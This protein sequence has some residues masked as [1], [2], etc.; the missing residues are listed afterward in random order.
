MISKRIKS[1]KDGKSSAGDSLRYGEGLKVD[2]ETGEYLDKSH[3]T[4]FGGFGLVDD[5]V[6][7]DLGIESM[8]EMIDLASIEMQANCDL[9]TRVRKDKKIGHFVISFDQD[10]PTEAALRDTEDSMLAAMKLDNNHFA[11]FLHNDNGYWHLHM[12]ASRIEKN[13]PHRGNS[14]WNDQTIRDKVCREIEIRHGLK[15]DNGM[16][17]IDQLGLIVEI[18]LAD[19]RAAREAKRESDPSISDKAKTTEIYS[20]EKTFQSWVNEIRMGDRLKHAK[21]WKDLHAAAAAYNCE[22]RIKSGGFILCPVGDIGG[23]QLSKIGLKNLPAKFGAFQ[24]ALPGSRIEPESIYKPGPTLAKAATHYEKWSVAKAAFKPAKTDRI[25]ELR[26][27][28]KAI[29]KQV[30]AQQKADIAKIYA[31]TSGQGKTADVSIAKMQYVVVLAALKDQF[32]HERQALRKKLAGADP[33]KTFRDYLVIEAA[34]GD[35]IS[36]GF[37]REYGVSGSTDVLAKREADQLVIVAAISGREY[38]PAQR[39]NF[40][41]R[42]E[43]NGTVV[44]DFGQGRIVTDSAVSKQVQLNHAAAADPQAIATALSFAATKFGNILTL[45]GE[46]EFQRLAV[47]TAVRNG[48]NINFKDPTLQKYKQEFAASISYPTRVHHPTYQQIQKGLQNVINRSP[49]PPAHILARGAGSLGRPADNLIRLEELPTSSQAEDRGSLHELPVGSLDSKIKISGVLLPGAVPGHV[50]DQQTGE[51]SSVR[52]PGASEVGSAGSGR[53]TGAAGQDVSTGSG[54]GEQTQRDDAGRAVRRERP[55]RL[56]EPASPDRDRIGI[57]LKDATPSMLDQQAQQAAAPAAEIPAA[58]PYEIAA[59]TP[60]M[61]VHDWLK[62]WIEDTGKSIGTA[63]A[64]NEDTAYIIVHIAPDGIVLDK[65]RTGAV[66]STPAD[67][68]LQVGDKV[69]VSNKAELRLPRIL[70]RDK[71]EPK[72]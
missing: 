25:N 17:E 43:R 72:R 19:R 51:H 10:K 39:M 40:S 28:H 2:R 32:A 38:R 71:D 41:H 61:S 66:Y 52:H 3:R 29:R 63:V 1:R 27:A 24:P 6:Y 69:V 58:I 12:F 33:G 36:L 44:Y 20:G 55:V 59:E 56:G 8:V 57:S 64:E 30:S 46:P 18:P 21:S 7:S 31:D 5:G 53:S 34:K 9:N 67:L 23:I 47:E 70:E 11:T 15:R 54:R 60:S 22:V 68:V 13:K 26:E 42:I 37:A 16:H 35:N 48:L 50:G 49:K 62:K 45:T 65:G 14:L 4:R